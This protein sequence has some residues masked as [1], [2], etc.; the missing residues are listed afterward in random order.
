MSVA[1]RLCT[2]PTASLAALS[3]LFTWADEVWLA[4][5]WATSSGGNATHWKAMPL[6]KVKRLNR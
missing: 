5:A 3:E 4:Y 2:S 1:I 6:A